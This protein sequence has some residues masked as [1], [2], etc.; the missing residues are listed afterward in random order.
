[1]NT[2]RSNTITPTNFFH[3]QHSNVRASQRGIRNP[4]IDIVI[5]EGKV[6]Y[7]QGIKFHYMTEKELRFYLPGLSDQLRS[8]VVVTA[9]DSNTI[10]TCYKN[11]HAIG[12][13]KRKSKRLFKK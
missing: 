10:I 6:T 1:M 13:I 2:L 3:T 8:L 12:N 5:R 7:K 4:H 11:K 9:G